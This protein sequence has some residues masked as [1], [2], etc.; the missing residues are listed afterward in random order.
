[1]T[2]AAEACFSIAAP[3]AWSRLT[4]TSALMPS[5]SIWLAMDFI[6]AGE[7]L[8]F[9]ML[10]SRLYLVQADFNAAGSAVTHRGEDVVSGRM[11]PTLMPLPLTAP[12]PPEDDEDVLAGVVA[13]PAGLVPPPLLFLLELHA[14][15]ARRGAPRTARGGVVF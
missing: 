15:T 4:M 5:P 8:A 6:V 2:P 10:Q 7:P 1:M 12:P 11:M 13:P 3:D 14:V 9:W